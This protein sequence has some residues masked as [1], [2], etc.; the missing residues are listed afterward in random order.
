VAVSFIGGGNQSTLRKTYCCMYTSPWTGFELTI[1]V[2]IDTDCTGSL[3]CDNEIK[4]NFK[5]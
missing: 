4:G 1:L 2:V 5:D 3:K